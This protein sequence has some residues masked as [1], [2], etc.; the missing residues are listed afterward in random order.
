MYHSIRVVPGTN[1]DI[2]HYSSELYQSAIELLNKLIST[3]SFSKEEDKTAELI[4]KHLSAHG[5]EYVKMDNNVFAFN[6]SVC[7]R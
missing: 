4:C 6:R 7:Y 2:M 5:V 3:P 1:Q